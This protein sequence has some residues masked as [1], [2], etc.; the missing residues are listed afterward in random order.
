[1][2]RACNRRVDDYEIAPGVPYPH[3]DTIIRGTKAAEFDDRLELYTGSV[4]IVIFADAALARRTAEL[5]R[6]L[7]EL[8]SAEASGHGAELPPPAPGPEC[9]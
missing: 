5:L 1:I 4:T 2:W 7:N 6:P 3:I 9:A 8:A